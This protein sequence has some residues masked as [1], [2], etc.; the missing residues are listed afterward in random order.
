MPGYRVAVLDDAGNELGPNQPGQL[1]IDIA[2]SPLLWFT[3]S[4]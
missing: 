4:Y 3:G 2:C 1:A